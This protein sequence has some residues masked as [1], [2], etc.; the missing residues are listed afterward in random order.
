MEASYI[1]DIFGRGPIF[2]HM[3]FILINFNV[4]F[5]DN[6]TQEQEFIGAESALIE[7][8]IKLIFLEY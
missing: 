7:V 4:G 3:Y 6:E 8:N 5:S 1:G 2:N